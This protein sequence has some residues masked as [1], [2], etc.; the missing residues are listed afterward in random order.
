MSHS[1]IFALILFLL[2]N[3][4]LQVKVMDKLDESLAA[5]VAGDFD[6]IPAEVIEVLVSQMDR[7]TLL[8][9]CQKSSDF[10]SFCKDRQLFDL[11]ALNVISYQAPLSG[12]FRTL[13]EQAEL[14]KRG[15]K[16]AYKFTFMDQVITK[17]GFGYQDDVKEFDDIDHFTGEFFIPGLPPTE[18]TVVWLII[19]YDGFNNNGQ[20]IKTS[21]YFDRESAIIDTYDG[22]EPATTSLSN[23]GRYSSGNRTVFLAQATLP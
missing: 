17:V 8:N 2:K 10:M 12:H 3:E 11:K 9:L 13:A 1:A 16:T 22:E 21:V 6:E 15:F 4:D 7:N 18:G 14:I 19:Y 5:F 23:T 20:I